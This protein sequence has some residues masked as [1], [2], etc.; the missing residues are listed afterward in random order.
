MKVPVTEGVYWVGAID[1]QIRDFHGHSTHKGTTYNAYLVVGKKVALVD[2]IKAPF[3]AEMCARIR[4]VIDPATISYLVVNHVEMDHSGSLPLFYAAFPQVEVLCTPR[5]EGELRRH[6]R[7]EIPLR[8]VK[9]GDVLELGGKTLRFVEVPMVHWPD[10][11]V[12]YVVEDKLLLANDAFGQH[13]ASS[14]RFDDELGWEFVKPEAAKYYANIVIPYGPQVL[15]ALD[16]LQGIPLQVIAPSHGLIWRTHVGEILATYRRWA[17]GETEGRVLVVYDTMWGSTEKMALAI[18]NGL[19]E[20]GVPVR[21]YPLRTSDPSD[22]VAEL[23]EARLDVLIGDLRILIRHR[24]ALVFEQLE[25]RLDLEFRREAQRLAGLVVDVAHVGRA[26]NHQPLFFGSFE[27]VLG[28]QLPEPL[29][30]HLIGVEALDEAD[31]RLA[32]AKAAQVD[33]LLDLG[34]GL[35]GGLRHLIGRNRD[36][37]GLPDFGRIGQRLTSLGGNPQVPS[38]QVAR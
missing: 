22:I 12:T 5:A 9:T 20:V 24:E 27:Q 28:D 10:S 17:E 31:G 37:E 29:L 38:D 34:H 25:S 7:G 3:F 6:Y 33:L 21:L 36:F 13:I 23:L 11:M 19:I 8:V 26:D 2:T 1:W 14:A 15:K 4:E 35:L 18:T 16:A 30:A 32:R